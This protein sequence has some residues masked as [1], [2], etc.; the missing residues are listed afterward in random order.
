M[1][2]LEQVAPTIAT[3]LLGPLGGLAVTAISKAIG[4]SEDD[5]EKTMCWWNTLRRFK[6]QRL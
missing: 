1:S 6:W 2:W 4:V 3:A 5:V